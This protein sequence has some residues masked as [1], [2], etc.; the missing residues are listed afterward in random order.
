M[1]ANFFGQHAN[2]PYCCKGHPDNKLSWPP[3]TQ[4]EEHK[5]K[6]L[7]MVILVVLTST[8][9]FADSANDAKTI[10]NVL[11]LAGYAC[12]VTTPKLDANEQ[13]DV[14]VDCTANTVADGVILTVSGSLVLNKATAGEIY[15]KVLIVSRQEAWVALAANIY[16]C[17]DK[18]K[19]I[20][21]WNACFRTCWART[22][23]E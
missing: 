6:K 19:D 16:A 17:S 2:N 5:M 3:A 10:Q 12:I 18:N 13:L 14:L 15:D 23:G 1:K 22:K 8:L 4:E 9:C 11:A 7:L 20:N 21:K